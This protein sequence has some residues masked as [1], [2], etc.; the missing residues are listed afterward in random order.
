MDLMKYPEVKSRCECLE[1]VISGHTEPISGT[2]YPLE[3]S[4]LRDIS[5]QRNLPNQ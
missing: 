3:S 4:D 2:A 5:N 1:V